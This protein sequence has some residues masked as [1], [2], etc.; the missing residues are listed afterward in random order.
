MRILTI[1]TFPFKELNAGAQERAV[2]L[3]NDVDRKLEDDM[4]FFA[5][6][7]LCPVLEGPCY[8]NPVCTECKTEMDIDT[9]EPKCSYCLANDYAGS[10]CDT[11]DQHGEP[12][13]HTHKCSPSDP[14]IVKGCPHCIGEQQVAYESAE[15]AH[16]IGG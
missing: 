13:C 8:S 4:N 3:L 16:E 10:A 1:A 7:T 11:E 9:G 5:D 15:K 6:G 14:C 12:Y 2:N